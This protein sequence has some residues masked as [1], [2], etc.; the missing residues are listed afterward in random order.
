MAVPVSI[1]ATQAGTNIDE[2][3]TTS[4]VRVEV[5]KADAGNTEV[6]IEGFGFYRRVVLTLPDELAG[7][8]ADHLAKVVA[9]QA[10]E[11]AFNL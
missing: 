3:G 8:L 7:P 9:G 1:I 11:G 2:G 10:Q 4:A 5:R 6:V